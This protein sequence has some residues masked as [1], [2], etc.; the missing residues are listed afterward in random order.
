MVCG[1]TAG[2]ADSNI[3]NCPIRIRIKSR[4]FASP[5]LWPFNPKATS[6]I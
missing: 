3:T 1:T 4:S 2:A 6:L 5:Y